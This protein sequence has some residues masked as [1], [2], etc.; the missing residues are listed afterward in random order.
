MIDKDKY[1]YFHVES[2]YD[3]NTWKVKKDCCCSV[4][5][6]VHNG[7]KKEDLPYGVDHETFLFR[8]HQLA[9]FDLCRNTLNELY[10]KLCSVGERNAVITDQNLATWLARYSVYWSEEKIHAIRQVIG[11]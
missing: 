2:F 3:D 6:Y 10:A 5:S 8:L 7:F 9:E 11:E 4:C 1:D